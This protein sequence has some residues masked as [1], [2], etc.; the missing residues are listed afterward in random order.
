LKTKNIT[1]AVQLTPCVG[2]L[3]QVVGKL[4]QNKNL[5]QKRT[6]AE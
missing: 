4:N 6:D 2:K 1:F 3:N 5:P